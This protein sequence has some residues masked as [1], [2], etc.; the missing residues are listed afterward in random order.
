MSHHHVLLH[1]WGKTPLKHMKCYKQLMGMRFCLDHKT[2]QWFKCFQEGR[3][4]VEDDLRSGR[5]KTTSNPELVD[6]VR[7]LLARDCQLTPR[8]TASELNVNKESKQS[9]ITTD[10]G[11]RKI[12]VNLCHTVCAR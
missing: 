9:I 7:N 10:L 1:S 11:K 12:C 5:P 6:K 2:F 3:E 8:M 4:D